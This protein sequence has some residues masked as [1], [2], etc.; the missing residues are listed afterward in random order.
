MNYWTLVYI[1]VKILHIVNIVLENYCAKLDHNKAYCVSIKFYYEIFSF[2][3]TFKTTQLISIALVC[4]PEHEG[5]TLF[6]HTLHRNWRNR[7]GIYQELHTWELAFTVLE[8][9]MQEA[10]EEIYQQ[11]LYVALNPGKYDGRAE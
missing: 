1:Q 7:A 5:K 11:Q 3:F 8:G 2:N 6:L 4:L 10:K 9:A